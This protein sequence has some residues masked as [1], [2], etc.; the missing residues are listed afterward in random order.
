MTE[1]EPVSFKQCLIHESKKAYKE[2]LIAIAVVI[3][4]IA[5]LIGLYWLYT[6]LNDLKDVF[7]LQITSA[8]NLISGIIVSVLTPIQDII[9]S[10]ATFIPWW[11]YVILLI[12]APPA[13]YS[14]LVCIQRHYKIDME[15][16]LFTIAV[17]YLFSLLIMGAF[18]IPKGILIPSWLIV[19]TIF[20]VCFGKLQR[21][22]PNGS[23]MKR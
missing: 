20:F 16:T 18:S 14:F 11:G 17:C 23:R 3:G 5:A 8:F 13:I 21:I 6:T 2:Y 4:F 7:A 22:N 10:V 15:G 12:I 9:W 1:N 19:G